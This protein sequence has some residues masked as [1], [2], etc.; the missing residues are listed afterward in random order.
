MST[1]NLKTMRHKSPVFEKL[2]EFISQGENRS[3][4]KLKIYRT[5]GSERFYNRAPK[6]CC[7]RSGVQ[8]EPSVFYRLD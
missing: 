3:G 2:L 6:T 5:N 4:K 1:Y 8:S 7:L